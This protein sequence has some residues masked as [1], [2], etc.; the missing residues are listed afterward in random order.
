[1]ETFFYRKLFRQ[2]NFEE[3]PSGEIEL[4]HSPTSVPQPKIPKVQSLDLPQVHKKPSPAQQKQVPKSASLDVPKSA[5]PHLEVEKSSNPFDKPPAVLNLSPSKI[6]SSQESIQYATISFD[7]AVSQAPPKFLKLDTNKKGA[8]NT[9]AI[10]FEK[11]V[12]VSPSKSLTI[13]TKTKKSKKD[14]KLKK[15]AKVEK[16]KKEPKVKK[17]KPKKE[18]KAVK[19][20]L[21]EEPHPGEAEKEPK[22]KKAKLEKPKKEPKVKKE[23]P[24]KEPKP[25][26]PMKEKPKKEKAIINDSNNEIVNIENIEDTKNKALTDIPSDKSNTSP[27]V[28]N[29]KE[30]KLKFF[31]FSK[32]ENKPETN[33]EA[34]VGDE[35]EV[36]TDPAKNENK[37]FVMS[38]PKIFSGENSSNA[39]TTNA[40]E[41]KLPQDSLQKQINVQ[42]INP[43][44][45][46]SLKKSTQFLP[47]VHKQNSASSSS[48][49]YGTLPVSPVPP[50]PSVTTAGSILPKNPHRE[51]LVNCLDHGV[52]AAS[53]MPKQASRTHTHLSLRI[54]SVNQLS[55]VVVVFPHFGHGHSCLSSIN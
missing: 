24:K 14:S 30:T 32:T 3:P 21:E 12:N 34:K 25:K 15:E 41:T 7:Q 45:K 11:P 2:S 52:V 40:T 44:P 29:N 16:P 20:N 36:I 54:L 33:I 13:T 23:K 39:L 35:T 22:P 9:A 8:V 10:P 19:E 17:E 51:K 53:K 18:A 50:K 47:E 43:N 26:V 38:W 46:P 28:K 1:M 27:E 6:T 42:K 5:S 31:N 37:K 49:G 4:A 55:I 48:S